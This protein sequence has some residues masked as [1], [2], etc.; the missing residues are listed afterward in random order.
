MWVGVP[1]QKRS[2][3]PTVGD[4]GFHCHVNVID[5]QNHTYFRRVTVKNA[6]NSGLRSHLVDGA[7]MREVWLG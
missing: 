5:I 3:S 1:F 4:A 6:S 7:G 2:A